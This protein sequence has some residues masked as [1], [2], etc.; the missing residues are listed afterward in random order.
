MKDLKS[1]SSALDADFP[2]GVF[3]SGLGGLRVLHHLFQAMPYKNFIY[4]ADLHHMPYGA[5]STNDIVRLSQKNIQWLS[6]KGC[7]LV[8][9][10]CHTST[11]C[12][13]NSK[14]VLPPYFLNMAP[15]LYDTVHSATLQHSL[16]SVAILATEVTVRSQVYQAGVSG[17]L[18]D[19]ELRALAC[20]SW[21][22]A[23]ESG[24]QAAKRDAVY[25]MLPHL[26]GVDALI[27]GCTHFSEMES[28]LQEYIPT[29]LRLDPACTL[30]SALR[31]HMHPSSNQTAGTVRIFTNV[32]SAP[33]LEHHA[34][35]MF[36]VDVE[37]I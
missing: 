7:Q 21:V 25:A 31:E 33:L 27:Y 13:E 9:A 3:D 1:M 30:A 8:L 37:Y 36:G 16:K 14:T 12:L 15:S 11:T 22:P 28:L 17:L 6:Q 19:L 32:T 10:A 4:F 34:E 23:I 20:P 18:P 26:D 2:I 5:R 29:V 24:S 35:R